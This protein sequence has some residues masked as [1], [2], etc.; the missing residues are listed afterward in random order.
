M[1]I[2]HEIHELEQRIA[3][4]RHLIE[5]TAHVTKEVAIKKVL[6]PVGLLSAAGIGFIATLG[7]TRRRHEYAAP[8]AVGK[9]GRI[10]G[11]AS[12]LASVAFA[13]L[14]AQFG[15]PAQMA[16]LVLA[17][18]RKSRQ[19]APQFRQPAPQPRQAARL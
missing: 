8:K 19:A 4:R 17:K 3:Q 9:G 18:F 12:V 6:S 11:I 14:R 1:H 5:R 13:M 16:Q 2:D 10:A 7:L 15:G